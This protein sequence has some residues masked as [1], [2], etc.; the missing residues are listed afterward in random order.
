[1]KRKFWC[2]LLFCRL[3]GREVSL[4][5]VRGS[6][7]DEKISLNLKKF[8]T[9]NCNDL[10]KRCTRNNF[11]HKFSYSKMNSVVKVW[12]E[13][14]LGSRLGFLAGIVAIAREVSSLGDLVPLTNQPTLLPRTYK[15]NDIKAG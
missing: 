4:L 9:L 10:E 2:Y 6:G 14:V 13:N 15:N 7:S 8:F 11:F 1:M 5:A 12:S 3:R